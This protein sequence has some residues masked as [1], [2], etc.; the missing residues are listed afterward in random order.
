M[1]DEDFAYLFTLW[2]LLERVSWIAQ[3]S[4]YAARYMLAQIVRFRLAKLRR[5][6]TK[7]RKIPDCTIE[8]GAPR[9]ERRRIDQPSRVEQL[10]LA[11]IA[12]SAT[13][14]AFE[15]DTFGDVEPRYLDELRPRLYH[16][17][18]KAITSCGLKMRPWNAR[19]QAAHVAPDPVIGEEDWSASTGLSRLWRVLVFPP[20]DDHPRSETRIVRVASDTR[21]HAGFH[22]SDLNVG[23]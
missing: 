13:A 1:P 16:P 3:Q 17:G 15:P 12:A 7:L 8:W 19:S 9:P 11:D 23:A 22:C 2:L 5:Y 20:A 21:N 10:Q 6:E 14:Q 4:N 18:G